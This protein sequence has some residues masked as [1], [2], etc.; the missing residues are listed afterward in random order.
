M[1]SLFTQIINGTAPGHILH[2]DDRAF[3]ILTIAPIRPGHALVIPRA[4]IDHWIDV[5]D[6]LLAHL[7]TVSRRVAAAIQAAYNPVKVGI[8]VAGLE[9]RHVHF[10][11]IP[12]QSL[13][14]M[15]F[16]RQ[17]R[18]VTAEE[19]SQSAALL[20]EKLRESPRKSD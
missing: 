14:D 15:N 11:L 12:I 5:P 10:H 9:V 17:N 13:E 6:E 2:E 7:M 1:P 16:A 20:R 3:A 4:E 8:M 18:S 19:L